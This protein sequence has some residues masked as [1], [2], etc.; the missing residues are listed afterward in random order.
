MMA[1]VRERPGT[2]PKPDNL[3]DI[4]PVKTSCTCDCE[5]PKGQ[6]CCRRPCSIECTD[7]EPEKYG[8]CPVLLG[9][10]AVRP[11]PQCKSDYDC[12]SC[13]KCCDICGFKCL[14]PKEGT[15]RPGTCPKPENL[16]DIIPV[17]TSCTCDCECP[18][19]QKCCR[20]PCSIE[21]T[22]VI[23]PEKY[24]TCPDL[25]DCIQIFPPQCKTDHDCPKCQKC[26]F[27]CGY[28]CEDPKEGAER[29]GTCPKPDNLCDVFPVYT[30]CT[31]DF[32]CAKGQKCCWKSCSIECTDLIMPGAIPIA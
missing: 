8:T 25:Y 24:G 31:C 9:C 21:C 7:V 10:T 22:D 5:C 17:K 20:R 14:D 26:C 15:E 27:V 16:C 6:K 19:G 23:M 11:P 18:K 12:P 30:S 32:E 1:K 3:C 29:P 13:Q 2:C 28:R 4:I